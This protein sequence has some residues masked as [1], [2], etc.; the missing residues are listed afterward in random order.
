MKFKIEVFIDGE[1]IDISDNLYFFEESGI[2]SIDNLED[3]YGRKVTIFITAQ[4]D[5][6]EHHKATFSENPCMT[7]IIISD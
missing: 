4:Y 2:R 5:D 3:F 6:H 7:Q 1:F